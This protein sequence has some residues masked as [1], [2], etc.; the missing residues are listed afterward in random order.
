MKTGAGGRTAV[1]E[2][3][4]RHGGH[5]PE[6]R[7]P[8][9]G[10]VERIAD[11]AASMCGGGGTD[12]RAA[13]QSGVSSAGSGSRLYGGLA[14]LPAPYPAGTTARAWRTRRW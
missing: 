12:K 14:V 9:P 5:L 10:P 1:P 8:A 11:P 3:R 2:Q 7:P 6:V 13:G 4:A